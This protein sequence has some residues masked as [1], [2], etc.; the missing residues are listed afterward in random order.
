MADDAITNATVMEVN[1]TIHASTT[2]EINIITV[3]IKL[4]CATAIAFLPFDN[5]PAIEKNIGAKA[6]QP[7]PAKK[8]P[9]KANINAKFLL[10]ST[11]NNDDDAIAVKPIPPINPPVLIQNCSL[12]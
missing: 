5:R 9:M 10:L 12:W 8:N 3:F 4:N 7:R 6:E 1:S 11:T 2:L